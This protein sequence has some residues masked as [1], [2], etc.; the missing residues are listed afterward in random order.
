M[1]KALAQARVCRLTLVPVMPCPNWV[2]ASL[3]FS[4]ERARTYLAS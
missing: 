4:P 3:A 1:E 2:L